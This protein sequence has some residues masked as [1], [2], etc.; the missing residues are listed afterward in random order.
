M[1]DEAD[2]RG[3]KSISRGENPPSQGTISPRGIGG[4]ESVEVIAK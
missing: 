2:P 1:P 4:W 3:E